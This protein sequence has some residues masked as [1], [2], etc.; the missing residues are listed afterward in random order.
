MPQAM[1]KRKKLVP[2]Q[3]LTISVSIKSLRNPRLDVSLPGRTS[4][5]SILDLKQSLS[6][7][8]GVPVAKMRLILNKKVCP[9]SK[10]LKDFVPEGESAVEFNVMVMGG[11]TS[12][13]VHTP[14]EEAEPAPS[15]VPQGSSERVGSAS[16]E[17]WGDLKEYLRQ[18]LRDEQ[19]VKELYGIFREAWEN[20]R[21][22]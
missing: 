19:E 16:D 22:D 5:T 2:G 14:T 8:A 15:A 13:I 7:K 12:A 17:F 1:K 9:D 10:I 3:D 20:K 11:A 21:K 6:E 18:R 4:N